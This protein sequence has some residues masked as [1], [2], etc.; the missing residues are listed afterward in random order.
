MTRASRWSVL[1]VAGAL[2][3][4]IAGGEAGAAGRRAPRQRRV[5]LRDSSGAVVGT[6]HYIWLSRNRVGIPLAAYEKLGV[7]VN[8]R[9]GSRQVTI[10]IPGSD[11]LATYTA[12]RRRVHQQAGADVHWFDSPFPVARQG[13]GTL[14]VSAYLVWADFQDLIIPEWDAGTRSLT[15]RRT[16]K[17]QRI[18]DHP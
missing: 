18:V 16:L 17:L 15:I 11:I 12:N 2:A 9:P 8:R 3:A 7:W 6:S 13:R 1:V 14:Y 10:G 5:V 4:G